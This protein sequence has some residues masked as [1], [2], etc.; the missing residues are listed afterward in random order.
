MSGD[1]SATFNGRYADEA[2][3]LL[4]REALRS[5]RPLREF[6]AKLI[7]GASVLSSVERELHV[8]D[9]PGRK[10]Y[11]MARLLAA[12]LGLSVQAEDF[13]G[14]G[15]RLV[16]FDVA[17]GDVWVRQSTERDLPRNPPTPTPSRRK[18]DKMTI[19]VMLVDDSAVV[20]QVL[21]AVF[22]QASGIEV[23]DVAHDPI[24]AMEKMKVRW[25]DV[26]VLDVEMPRMDGITFP[27]AVDEHAADAGGDLLVADAEG[28]RHGHERAGSRRGWR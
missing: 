10:H 12:Q 22:T 24:M 13:G 9:V 21:T 6:H 17:C 3:L 4:V 5:G 19:R 26:I 25:P 2:M 23:A 20:R 14:G 28:L 15:A 11:V 7:G 16:L 27:Q 1:H 8:T 18:A